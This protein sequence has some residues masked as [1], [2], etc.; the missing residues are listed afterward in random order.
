M[1]YE[2]LKA[3]Q[4]PK[5]PKAV[6]KLVVANYF[7]KSPQALATAAGVSRAAV[8]KWPPKVSPVSMFTYLLV[9]VETEIK[10]AN[11]RS[12]DLSELKMGLR[13]SLQRE[14]ADEEAREWFR[15]NPR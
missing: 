12:R 10:A 7:G 6:L 5:D 15:K 11:Q 4:L 9:A 14:Q 13:E 2:K 1:A 3:V 8:N